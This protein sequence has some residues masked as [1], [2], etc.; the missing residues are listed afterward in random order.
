MAASSAAAFW[1]TALLL[2]MVPGADWAFVISSGL[3]GHSPVPAVAG[4]IAGYAGVTAVVAAGVGLLVA[5]SPVLLAALTAAG[6]V[7]LIWHGAG[8]F[9]RAAAP[10]P[11]AAGPAGGRVSPAQTRRAQA[12]SDQASDAETRLAQ[13]RTD[14]DSPARAGGAARAVLVR[15]IGV[16]A[17]N[18]KGL[19][20]LLALLPQFTSSRSSWP[21]TVQLGFLG[22]IFM[23]TVAVFY[24]CLGFLA[25]KVLL[26]RPGAARAV[27]R[28][29]GAAMIVIGALLLAGR[30]V[31]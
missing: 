15:G 17:L 1:L 22:V 25:R 3:R 8:T 27:T 14:Q 24:L 20:L 16:S 28:C 9:A 5:R 29:S 30:F 23:L 11:Q 4:L 18:P 2:V 10:G 6:G 13:V 12:R 19:L 26:T 31:H 21:L 7:Y